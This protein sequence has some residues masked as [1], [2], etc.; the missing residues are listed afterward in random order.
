M[1]I[2]PEMLYCSTRWLKG[3]RLARFLATIVDNSALP[4]V[5]RPLLQASRGDPG[6]PWRSTIGRLHGIHRPF[7]KAFTSLIG[8]RTSWKSSK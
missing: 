4:T 1:A 6:L 5:A 7:L 8:Q 3:K 2:A